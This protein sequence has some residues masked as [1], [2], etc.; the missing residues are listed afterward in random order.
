VG[1]TGDT[2]CIQEIPVFREI[3]RLKEI[4]VFSESVL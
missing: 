1:H 3:N 2:E 4:P